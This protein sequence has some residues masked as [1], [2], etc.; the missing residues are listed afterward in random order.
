MALLLGSFFAGMITVL[1]PCV[2]PLLPVIIGGSVTGE[3]VDKRR[4]LFVVLSLGV[5]LFLFTLLL[6]A[7]TLLIA[8]P[9]F[10]IT[11]ISGGILAL[12][13]L[14][15][16]FP[17]TYARI[18]LALGIEQKAQSLLGKG[19][20]NKNSLIGPM[21]TGATLGPVFSS[22]S[23]VYAYILATI[24]PESFAQ[25]VVYITV[26]IIGLCVSL[27][28]IGYGGQRFAAKIGFLGNPE[29]KFQKVIGVIFI[30]V[31]LLVVSGYDKK[32]QVWVSEHTVFNFDGISAQFIPGRTVGIDRGGLLN[33]EPYAAPELLELEGWINSEPQ[34]LAA[35]KG[36]VVLIDF[37]TYSCINCIRSIP[38]VEKWYETYK[39]SG[40]VVLGLHAPEFAFERV[41]EN[42]E[43]A[44]KEYGITYPV[45]L[46]NGFKTWNAFRNQYWPAH[47]LIDAEGN[48]RRTHFG[49]GE[50]Q[51]TEE[52][53]RIL[54]E[55]SGK[56][57]SSVKLSTTGTEKV[58]SRRDQTPETY[59]GLK[60]VGNYVGTPALGVSTPASFAYAPNLSL[61]QWSLSGSWEVTDEQIVARGG[62]T[63]KIK[64]SAKDVYL[65]MESPVKK[66]VGVSLDGVVQKSV[67]V[68]GSKLY[69]II[70]LPKFEPGKVLEL[71]IPEG[72]RLNAFTFGS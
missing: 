16:L 18:L 69:T 32:I 41:P 23:P 37:W 42:V 70:S 55:E 21:I 12:L 20:D 47:Y 60:R 33:V 6:K 9:P 1:A 24:L 17:F 39:D 2:L 19:I 65:V 28:V 72:V 36:K 67:S 10:L 30:I 46:D 35:L 59:L 71:T 45:A 31:G 44:V 7:T 15:L 57:L 43:K 49:E 14:A 26:Y 34:T 27:L 40:F 54:L 61:D 29:G 13:G 3:V 48:I 11:A 53:I 63:L 38:F 66:E 5:S 62:S 50:Y 4:P 52:T 25:A 64:I 51:E 8:I 58:P 22:C 56:D 68:E